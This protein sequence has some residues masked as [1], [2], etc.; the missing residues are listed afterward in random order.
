MTGRHFSSERCAPFRIWIFGWLVEPRRLEAAWDY[1]FFFS[2]PSFFPHRFPFELWG[3]VSR[4]LLL[5]L[6]LSPLHCSVSQAVGER[7]RKGGEWRMA[8]YA[9]WA[10]T[11][12]E[13]VSHRLSVKEHSP[14]PTHTRLWMGLF[15]LTNSGWCTHTLTRSHKKHSD[16]S[17]DEKKKT[18]QEIGS[19]YHNKVAPQSTSSPRWQ[20]YFG[21]NKLII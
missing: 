8:G 12:G 1:V 16:K 15:L 9:N 19:K 18:L 4:S 20:Y 2:S 13:G 11:K 14:S 3:S 5:S 17:F 7:E 10:T 6:S 21:K